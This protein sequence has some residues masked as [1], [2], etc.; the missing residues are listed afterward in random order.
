[1]NMCHALDIGLGWS[2]TKEVIRR[3]GFV[4][5]EL[6][7]PERAQE[8]RDDFDEHYE[9]SETKDAVVAFLQGIGGA[10]RPPDPPAAD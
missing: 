3:R 7:D 1:M 8:L 9:A 5:E 10:M 2:T 4:M 6:P